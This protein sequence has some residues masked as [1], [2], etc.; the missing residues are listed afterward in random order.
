[1]PFVVLVVS[2]ELKRVNY[3][4][5][6]QTQADTNSTTSTPAPPNSASATQLQATNPPVMITC[7]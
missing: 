5:E 2:S 3:Q 1:M 6:G 7:K 4:V